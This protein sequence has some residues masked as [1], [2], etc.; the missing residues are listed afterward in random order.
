[1]KLPLLPPIEPMLA[2]A[3]AKVP[4]GSYIYEPKWDGYRC[5]VFRDGA[6]ID[7]GSRGGK[8]L[9]RYFPELA[10]SLLAALPSRCVLDG[11]IV[12]VVDDR[13]D[14]DRLGD[15]IHPAA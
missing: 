13:L 5:L 10:A 4:T 6:E 7:L 8:S 12:V 11:E 2:K 14:F 1:M 3:A 15:R 9:T